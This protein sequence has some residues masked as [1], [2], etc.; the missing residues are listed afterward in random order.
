MKRLLASVS[1]ATMMIAAVPAFT[2]AFAQ[3]KQGGEMVVTFKDDLITLD[4]AIGYD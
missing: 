4:P 2:P 1:I 3:A